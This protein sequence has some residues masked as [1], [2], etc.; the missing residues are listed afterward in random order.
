MNA[1]ADFA[2]K[3][4]FTRRLGLTLIIAAVFL[5]LEFLGTYFFGNRFMEEFTR[6][7]ELQQSTRH[8]VAATEAIDAAA[9]SLNNAN[10]NPSTTLIEE[11]NYQEYQGLVTENLR[12]FEEKL[13]DHPG[14]Y[15]LIATA[16][17]PLRD[18]RAAA[19]SSFETLKATDAPLPAGDL[20]VASQFKLEFK[21]ILDKVRLTVRTELDESFPALYRQRFYPLVTGAMLM[22]FLLAILSTLGFTLTRSFKNSV[23]NL[24]STTERVAKGDL[25]VQAPVLSEDEFGRLTHAFN[26]MVQDLSGIT[27]SRDAWEKQN[28]ELQRS[29]QELEQFAFFASHDL[30]EPLRKIQSFTELLGEY[31]GDSLDP[32]ARKYMAYVTEGTTRMRQLIQDLLVYSRAGSRELQKAPTDFN[33]LV[34]RVIDVLED[35]IR[36]AGA[37]IVVEPLPTVFATPTLMEQVFQNLVA[38]AVKFRAPD[39]PAKVRISATLTGSEW[40]F[41][42][43]DNGIGIDAHYYGKIFEI[44]QRLHAQK[45]YKGTGIGL[46]L[47]KKI[48]ERHGGRIWVEST[49][50]EGSDFKI[51]LPAAA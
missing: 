44:F 51:A 35:P 29:N 49:L 41:S 28:S 26:A 11:Q 2:Q 36:G 16:K 17:R 19:A 10:A 46:A 38:N 39:R 24:L 3:T 37:E 14:F 33:E 21:E 32:E 43:K 13:A 42:V 9:E 23:Q 30:Q 1:H 22:F 27:V 15:K 45:E 12:S 25:S 7:F 8:L 6:V 20:M 48:M 5:V 31:L 34:A 50:G 40:I 4:S 47:C 18:F